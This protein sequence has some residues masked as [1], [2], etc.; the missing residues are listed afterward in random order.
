MDEVSELLGK[1]D[2]ITEGQ[3][4]SLRVKDPEVSAIGQH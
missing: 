4:G 1:G 2:S 3:L